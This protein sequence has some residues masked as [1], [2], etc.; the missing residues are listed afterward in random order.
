MDK[1]IKIKTGEIH[2]DKQNCVFV[3]VLCKDAMPFINLKEQKKNRDKNMKIPMVLMQF[4]WD[5]K[6]GFP[7]GKVD[8]LDKENGIVTKETLIKSLVREMEEELNL[9]TSTVDISKFKPLCTFL[10]KNNCI[11]NFIY[12]VSFDEL[13]K[14]YRD[15]VDVDNILSENCGSIVLHLKEYSTD[16]GLAAIRSHKYCA[17]ALLELEEVLKYLEIC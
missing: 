2:K 14:I 17:T 16:K 1:I 15:T 9:D 7:G 8:D 4:R 6:I 13:K 10:M 11:H 12:E 5:G 3:S